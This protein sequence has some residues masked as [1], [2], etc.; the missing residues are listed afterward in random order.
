[1]SE[2]EGVSLYLVIPW[3]GAEPGMRHGDIVLHNSI[4][5]LHHK[6][7]PMAGM[8][9]TDKKDQPK[10]GMPRQR[11]FEREP[12]RQAC[13]AWGRPAPHNQLSIPRH[14]GTSSCMVGTA[15]DRR[16]AQ[17]GRVEYGCA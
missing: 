7:S 9:H 10:R 3:I 2:A 14:A 15:W 13:K 5:A 4:P 1:M 8:P 17:F 16:D 12:R 11:R 6:T